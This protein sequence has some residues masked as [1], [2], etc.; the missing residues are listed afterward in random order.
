MSRV[1]PETASSSTGVDLDEITN[2][3]IKEF[4]KLYVPAAVCDWYQVC[5]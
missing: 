2:S 1:Y 5:N 4:L 3:R